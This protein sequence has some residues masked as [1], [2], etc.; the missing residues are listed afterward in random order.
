MATAADEP[1]P[2]DTRSDYTLPAGCVLRFIPAGTTHVLVALDIEGL[3]QNMVTDQDFARIGGIFIAFNERTSEHV[4]IGYLDLKGYVHGVSRTDANEVPEDEWHLH[5]LTMTRF[6]KQS[7]YAPL[8]A[9]I[10]LD[11]VY[12]GPLSAAERQL[13]MARHLD[14]TLNVLHAAVAEESEER[15]RQA[16]AAAAAAGAPISADVNERVKIVY[17]TDTCAYDFGKLNELLRSAGIRTPLQYARVPPHTYGTLMN[18][19]DMAR[20]LLLEVDRARTTSGNKIQRLQ[21]LYALP[22]DV[23]KH[24]HNP[25]H[26]AYTIA[27]MYIAVM[28]ITARHFPRLT[29]EQTDWAVRQ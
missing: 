1:P 24:T 22:P 23:Y 26:D 7:P 3:G 14:A 21:A 10:L 5:D 19:G 28:G 4:I 25:V 18:T 6:F 8:T 20:T 27:Y 29:D 12:D 9:P 17:L 2:L 13:E 15:T 11:C 16:Q